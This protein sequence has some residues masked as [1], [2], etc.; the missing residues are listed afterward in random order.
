MLFKVKH[1]DIKL[2][3]LR[4]RFIETAKYD[5]AEDRLIKSWEH[6]EQIFKKTSYKGSR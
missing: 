5:I 2:G 3:L 4:D 1:K 6:F